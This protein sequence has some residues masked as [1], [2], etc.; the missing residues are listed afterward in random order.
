MKIEN[1][2]KITGHKFAP[3][4]IRVYVCGY[5]LELGNPGWSMVR[6]NIACAANPFAY[7]ANMYWV[8]KDK[9]FNKKFHKLES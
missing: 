9:D 7:V 8:F 1:L 3:E 2:I 5:E 4:S 6:Q